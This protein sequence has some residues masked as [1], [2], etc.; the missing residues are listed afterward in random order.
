MFTYVKNFTHL[1]TN[2]L[3]EN[4]LIEVELKPIPPASDW[5]D[6]LIDLPD[7]SKSKLESLLLWEWMR[8]CEGFGLIRIV[9]LNSAPP[10]FYT[11]S[12]DT[13]FFSF[14]FFLLSSFSSPSSRP[15][16]SLS[17]SQFISLSLSLSISRSIFLNLPPPSTKSSQGQRLKSIPKQNPTHSI[18][19][20]CKPHR[21]PPSLSQIREKKKKPSQRLKTKP[22]KLT[23]FSLIKYHSNKLDFFPTYFYPRSLKSVNKTLNFYICNQ[24]LIKMWNKCIL[25][26]AAGT[27]VKTKVYSYFY[28]WHNYWNKC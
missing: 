9:W 5:H 14:S 17:F 4:H 25:I 12:L 20:S 28:G 1:D 24:L 3:R 15:S 16:S 2:A 8:A 18:I 26:S 7:L 13:F 27:T 23:K 21:S 22:G 10:T 19:N 11:F 6:I